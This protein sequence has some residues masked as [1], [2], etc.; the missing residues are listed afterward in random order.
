ME[1]EME[2]DLR[3]AVTISFAMHRVPGP[4]S[5]GNPDTRQ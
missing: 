2:I 1:I 3:K 5:V 4:P